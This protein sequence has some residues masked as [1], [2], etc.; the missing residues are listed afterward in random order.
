MEVVKWQFSVPKSRTIW[1]LAHYSDVMMGPMASQVTSLTLVYSTVY[2]GADQRK[3][4]SSASLAFMRG[5]HRAHYDVIVMDFPLNITFGSCKT[6][7]GRAT[8]ICVSKLTIVG[9]DNGLSPGRRQAIIWTNAGILSI[10]TLGT[11]FNE[12]LS[13][14]H[15]FSVKKMHL[16]MS[17]GKWQPFWLGLNVLTM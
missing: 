9:S 11:S 12:N 13:E 10:D 1:N 3:H 5:I 6:H 17:S 14:I 15:A 8:H 16:K 4:Q 2:S 7:W